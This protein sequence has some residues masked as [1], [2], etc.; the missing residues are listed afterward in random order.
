M[1][2]INW[3]AKGERIAMSQQVDLITEADLRHI[4]GT[5]EDLESSC[6]SAVDCWKGIENFKTHRDQIPY[7]PYIGSDYRGILFAGINL[8][9]VMG[10]STA[11]AQLV[12]EA[13][14]DY[15]RKGRYK[16]FQ[17]E[18]YG[19]SPFYYYV[20]LLAYLYSL[21]N[22]NAAL[23]KHESEITCEQVIDG[24]RYCAL[25]NLIKCSVNSPDNRSTPSKAM[26]RNCINRFA[27]ELKLLKCRVL[28]VFTRFRFP[29]IA[30][31]LGDYELIAAGPRHRIQSNGHS[32]LLELEHPLSTQT[33]RR[34]KFASY[35]GAIYDLVQILRSCRRQ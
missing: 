10:I 34:N 32:Y 8:Y 28:V 23:I 30:D 26:Y 12:E 14:E 18:T 22:S 6:T 17:S 16:I 20:P 3:K 27:Q 2:Q 25:T 1:Q 29:T 7:L 13:I 19:G 35:S 24:Y 4:Y 15:L 31:H 5:T 33:T 11:I 21:Y 9:G